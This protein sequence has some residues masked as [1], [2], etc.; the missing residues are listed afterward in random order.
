MTTTTNEAAER[1]REGIEHA[2]F[3]PS[4]REGWHRDLNEALAA[5]YEEG[6][7][8]A[9]RDWVLAERDTRRATV[10]RI[11]ERWNAAKWGMAD[12]TVQRIL[13]EEAAR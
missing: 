4:W 7:A 5:A 2:R 11:R 6:H 10:E 13:D 1:L 3:H 8:A 9:R 12:P